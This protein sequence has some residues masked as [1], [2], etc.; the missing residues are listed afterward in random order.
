[1]NLKKNIIHRIL[2]LDLWLHLWCYA[3]IWYVNALIISK[4]H[5]AAE[6]DRHCRR[7]DMVG[8]PTVSGCKDVHRSVAVVVMRGGWKR[9][10]HGA[11]SLQPAVQPVG[12]TMKMSAAKRRLSGPARTLTASLGWRQRWNWVTFSDPVTRE[13]SDPETQ[14]IRWPND[15]VPCVV[16]ARSKA[17]VW[18]VDDVA[19]VWSNF[20]EKEFLLHVLPSVACGPGPWGWQKLARSQNSTILYFITRIRIPTAGVAFGRYRSVF[21]SC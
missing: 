5:V 13:S 11:Y 15:P 18:T 14:L 1:M 8:N 9:L 4:A 17:A 21:L 20:F 7:H 3:I 12:W 16:D 2:I 19:R 6:L 10:W